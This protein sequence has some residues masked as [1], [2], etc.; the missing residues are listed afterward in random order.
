MRSIYSASDSRGLLDRQPMVARFRVRE[1]PPGQAFTF[2]LVSAPTNPAPADS[3]LDALAEVFVGVQRNGSG[4]DDVILL[5]SLNVSS[6][7]SGRLGRLAN[8]S[9]V[10]TGMPTNTRQT[11]TS[12]NILFDSA[13]T[14]EYTGRS[15]VLNWM[16]EY[17]LTVEQALTVSEHLPVWAEFSV[18]EGGTGPLARL[19]SE[20]SRHAE[21]P[22]VR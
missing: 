11:H 15:G 17:G 3:V 12:A 6:H 9:A 7:R 5:G 19:P 20:M 8:V 18:Y 16:T 14:V 21:N 1:V 4:E 10:I 22:L 2:T 13:A